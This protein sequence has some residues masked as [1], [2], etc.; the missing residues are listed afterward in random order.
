MERVALSRVGVPL[1]DEE[2]DSVVLLV[3]ARD[4]LRVRLRLRARLRG[5]LWLRG[6]L[7]GRPRVRA[8]G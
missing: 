5:R 7:R 8:M 3:R 6:R 4:R 1:V 2:G